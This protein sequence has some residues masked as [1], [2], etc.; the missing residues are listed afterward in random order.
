VGKV[1]IRYY[2]THQHAGKPKYG[3]WSPCLK[4]KN[5]KTGKIEPTLMAK[6]GFELQDCGEDGPAAWAIAERWNERWDRA[7]KAHLAGEP[8]EPLTPVERQEPVW[9]KDSLGEAFA[10]LR[11]TATWHQKAK[12]TKD[13]WWRGWNHIA[14]VFGD[15]A[16]PTISFEM[17]DRW[18][19]GDPKDP[20]VKGLLQTL[21]VREAHRVMKIWRALYAM[22]LVLKKDNGEHYATARDPS[23]GIRRQT[24]KPRNAFWLYDEAVGCVK[25]A[26]RMGYLGLAA[27]LAVA[28]DTMLSPVDVRKLTLAQLKGDHKGP[29]FTLDRAKTGKTAIGT[30]SKRTYRLLKFYI[31]SLPFELHDDAPIF[32]TPGAQTGPKGGRRWLPQPYSKDLLGKH[33]RIVREAASPGDTRKLSDFRRSGAIEVT[34][35]EGSEQ[36]LAGKM[37]NS[38][39][40][41]RELQET[42]TPHTAALVRLADAA[43]ERGRKALRP[44]KEERS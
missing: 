33:F 35:G 4:R 8:V 2:V 3:Y 24:P 6:L 5:K 31:E 9:P 14:P 10:R 34:A 41:N 28:W 39:D 23:L 22:C 30:L 27:A 7:R 37:A 16:V 38:I 1:K 26:I 17:L 20:A 25:R 42:Y 11:A 44:P 32:R 15:C 36:A 29:F 12:A 19:G 13:D 40:S 43:R 21:G 18:Y